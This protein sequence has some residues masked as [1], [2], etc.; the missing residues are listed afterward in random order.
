MDPSQLELDEF[1]IECEIRGLDYNQDQ[2]AR[3][4]DSMIV[5][6]ESALRQIPIALHAS[7]K[8]K[9]GEVAEIQSKLN[10]IE[11][12]L[13]YK[14]GDPSQLLKCHSR[15]MH[16]QARILRLLPYVG[17]HA[18]AERVRQDIEKKLRNSIGL[19]SGTIHDPVQDSGAWGG[20]ARVEDQQAQALLG[21]LHG[22]RGRGTPSSVRSK[23]PSTGNPIIGQPL[24][25][26]NQLGETPVPP[27]NSHNVDV[28]ETLQPAPANL[29]HAPE[30]DRL[31]RYSLGSS[32]IG[33]VQYDVSRPPPAIPLPAVP[34]VPRTPLPPPAAIAQPLPVQGFQD[35]PQGGNLTQAWAMGRWPLRFSGGP[36]DLHIDLFIFRAETL[37]R[38]ANLPLAALA[39]GLH[40]ILTGTA[41]SW[42]WLFLQNEP[43]ATWAEIKSALK[44]AFQPNASDEAIRRLI[45]DRMQRNGERFLEFSIAIR[46][47]E[48]RLV[49]RMT[50][51]EIL[52]TLRN[53]MLPH[54][55]DRLLFV[56]IASVRE[57]QMRV[58]QVE[59]LGQRQSEVQQLRRSAARVHEIAA[60]PMATTEHNAAPIYDPYSIGISQL[61]ESKAADSRTNFLT[62]PPVRTEATNPFSQ[63]NDQ[64]D[65][66]CAMMNTPADQNQ[67][68]VCWNCDDIGHTF[69]DCS[70][71]R[72]IFCYGCGTKNV[73]RPQCQKCSSRLLSGNVRR[74]VRSILPPQAERKAEGQTFQQIYQH[75]PN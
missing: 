47:L 52:N 72:S 69:M 62:P 1:Q 50:E 4:L 5:E 71:T 29:L 11:P 65:Y 34:L 39:L 26:A 35:L 59:E 8:T 61:S 53:N 48:N 54:I 20:E 37:A 36:K 12:T 64:Q 67:F 63:P 31:S 24:P 25:P 73:V 28:V 23:Q 45:A 6:E 70:A 16:L 7:L 22:G 2:I 74:N 17:S 51:R 43:N 15:L 57:L 19:M 55:Q 68:T 60:N 38:Q 58:H 27:Y 10:T 40:H 56:T 32:P 14:S 46:E 18:Q 9:T 49:E 75:R 13:A 66:L 30:L 44:L 41:S 3:T 21:V 33:L 42:Y